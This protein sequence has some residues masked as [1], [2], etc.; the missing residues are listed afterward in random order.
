MAGLGLGRAARVM[1]FA[2]LV[3]VST[4]PARVIAAGDAG[5]FLS[6]LSDKAIDQL[7]VA[8]LSH[9]EKEQRFRK[10]MVQ[11]FDIPAIGQFVLGRYW[12]TAGRPDQ[13]A[14]LSV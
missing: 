5:A 3:G 12:R 6:D 14:F 7:T 2:V 4:L 10:L 11:G 1:A 9:Q 13:A 8:G